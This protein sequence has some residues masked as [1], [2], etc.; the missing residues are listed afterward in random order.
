MAILMV[1]NNDM[2]I[3]KM[4]EYLDT[5]HIVELDGCR[6]YWIEEDANLLTIHYGKPGFKVDLTIV[7]EDKNPTKYKDCIQLNVDEIERLIGMDDGTALIND[8]E[9]ES[10]NETEDFYLIKFYKKVKPNGN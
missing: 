6:I 8:M 4:Q 2:N 10:L 3:P 7:P 5:D 9:I 1:D